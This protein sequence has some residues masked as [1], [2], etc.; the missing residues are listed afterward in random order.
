[1]L[2]VD[3]LALPGVD[4]CADFDP[5]GAD[6]LNDLLSGTNCPRRAVERREEAVSGRVVLDATPPL[7]RSRISA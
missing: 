2:A 1:V 3:D 7:Q 6:T 4:A 5:D